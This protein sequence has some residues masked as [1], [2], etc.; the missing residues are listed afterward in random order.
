LPR[1]LAEIYAHGIKPDWWKLPSM[2][3]ESWRRVAVEIKNNDPYC[4]GVVL[5]GLEAPEDELA[6]AFKIARRHPICKGFAIGRSI[7]MAPARDWLLGN[8]DAEAFAANVADNYR[9]LIEIWLAPQS[10]AA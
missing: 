3:D 10:A 8:C 6:A 2:S 7:F 9:R 1:C 4:R 5:L